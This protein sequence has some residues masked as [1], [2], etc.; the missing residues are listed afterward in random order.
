MNLQS[1]LY[2]SVLGAVVSAEDIE[3]H[4]VPQACVSDCS[5]LIKLSVTCE[6]QTDGDSAFND[7]VCKDRNAKSAFNSCAACAKQ[8]GFTAHDDNG[9]SLFVLVTTLISIHA[10]GPG[11]LP[12]TRTDVADLMQECS[13]DF[14]AAKTAPTNNSVVVATTTVTSG[15]TAV[16]LT[17]TVTQSPASQ[18]TGA[19][20]G[21]TD[22][23]G[24]AAHA[25]PGVGG[26]VAVLVLGHPALFLRTT[27]LITFGETEGVP[28]M[29]LFPCDE[30]LS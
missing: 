9:D 26:I 15:S 18:S 6:D 24:A 17:T 1:V 27:C 5:D 30:K 7:C 12:K 20:A 22:A 25:I 2:L 28:T 29:A 11:V 10:C 14:D 19:A 3:E 8:N 4:D 23:T 16:P 13:L 21:T